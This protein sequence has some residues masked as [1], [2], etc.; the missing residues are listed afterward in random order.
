M[1][2]ILNQI[3]NGKTLLSDG[4]WGTFL[5]VKGLKPGECP[6]L[7]NKT[8][9]EDVLDVAQSYIAAGSDMI[10]TNSFGGSRIK[11]DHYGLADDCYE[12]NKLAAEISREAAGD[13]L[14]LGS[15]G[16][17]GKFL[18]MGEV[19]EDELYDSFKVQA[20]GLA[21]GGA[22]T[23]CIETFYALDEA[24]I[25]IRAAKEKTSLK[26]IAT[27]TFDKSSDGRFNTM[28]GVVPEAIVEPLINAGADIIG[29]NCG[30]GFED[31]IPIIEKIRACNKDI[32]LL[33]HANAG[34]P[35]MK[36]GQMEYPDTP[37]IMSD[38]ASRLIDAGANIIGGCCGTTP[39]HIKNIREV[40][41]KIN[42]AK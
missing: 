19:T 20:A 7:W 22:D 25:A 41:D 33:V 42:N 1:R 3:K 14:V 9:R 38:L 15:I 26:I 30:I 29:T 21:D 37:E 35:E 23:I 24:E 40:I 17:T 6:E 12:L 39:E 28:M 36:D 8:H 16:P 27:F 2:S 10:E 5:Q 11:L 31:M 13:K 18:M 34:L 32:P 4:G